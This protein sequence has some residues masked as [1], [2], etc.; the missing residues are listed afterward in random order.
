MPSC[1]RRWACSIVL[2]VAWRSG[3]CGGPHPARRS[4]R[5]S[6]RQAPGRDCRE[7]NELRRGPRYRRRGEVSRLM[8]RVFTVPPVSI[9][10]GAE[11]IPKRRGAGS[12]F[13]GSRRTAFGLGG[14]AR[15]RAAACRHPAHYLDYLEADS[16]RGGRARSRHDH[17][18]GE[19]S[20]PRQ[21]RRGD[22]GREL[23]AGRTPA[24]AAVR[25]GHHALADRAMGFACWAMW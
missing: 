7:Q 4:F 6:L 9:T 3:A 25:P 15:D 10:A 11:D 12:S 23:R 8:T 14:R 21:R 22:R 5:E 20:R 16:G 17:Q 13:P 1:S 24:L 2:V 19:L 18:R